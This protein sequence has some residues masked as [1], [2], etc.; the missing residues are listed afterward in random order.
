MKELY[1]LP[2]EE[3]KPAIYKELE[4]EMPEDVAGPGADE[5]S[6]RRGKRKA[7]AEFERE[8]EGRY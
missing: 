3:L 6:V 8:E 7:P 4:R 1:D 5:G 2:I